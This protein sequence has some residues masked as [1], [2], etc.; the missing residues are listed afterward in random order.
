MK[1]GIVGIPNVGKTS[2][3]NL[4]TKCQAKVDLYPF[5]TIEKNIGIVCVPDERLEKICEITK[6][7]IKTYATIEFVDIAGLVKGASEGEGLGNKFLSHIREADLI[8]H[9][10]RDFN[11]QIPH[12]YSSPNPERDLDIC[13]MELALADLNIIENNLQKIGKVPTLKE[14]KE[15]MIKVKEHLI[16]GE[17]D[18]NL[19]EEERNLLKKYNLFVLKPRIYAVNADKNNGFDIEK[20]PKLKEK[21]PYIF[22]TAL[23]EEII[24]LSEEEKKEYRKILNLNEEG[25]MGLVSECFRTLSLIR[26][27]TIKGEETRAWSIKKGSK[28]SEAAEKIHTDIAKGFIKAEVINYKDLIEIGDYHKAKEKGL[29]RIEGRDYIVEDGDIILIRFKV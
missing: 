5:T 29:V 15:A 20:Y 11:N 27:Y 2:L 21:K 4:L 8:L 19:N 3:F 10:L 6:P 17:I 24:N 22:S 16:R 7:K 26:F 1:V 28:V 9:L 18:I 12:I 23:E 13:E 14:E 25:I